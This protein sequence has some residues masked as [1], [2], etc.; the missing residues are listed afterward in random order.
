[1]VDGTAAAV[2]GGRRVNEIGLLGLAGTVGT[3]LSSCWSVFL[4]L[5]SAAAEG[6]P[7]KGFPV[8]ESSLEEGVNGRSLLLG[9]TLR[10]PDPGTAGLRR[11]LGGSLLGSSL[12]RGILLMGRPELEEALGTSGRSS[13]ILGLSLLMDGEL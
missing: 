1:M 3:L 5:E 10:T 8:V 7:A 9:V 11:L 12:S 13:S 2:G 6:F 4:F